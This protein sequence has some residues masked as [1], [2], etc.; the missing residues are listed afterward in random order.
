MTVEDVAA[1][2]AELSHDVDSPAGRRNSVVAFLDAHATWVVLA[3]AAFAV[4]VG[5]VLRY[6]YY[7]F[8]EPGPDSD[9]AEFGLLAEQLLRGELPL[10]MRGQP[11]GG[12]PWLFAIAASIRAFGMNSFGLRLPTIVLGLVNSGLVFGIG[13]Q[14]GWTRRRAVLAAAGVWC[15]PI[16]AVYFASR[17]TM[18]FVPAISG[19]LAALFFVLRME[20]R[21]DPDELLGTGVVS[22]RGLFLAG[23]VAGAGFWVNPGSFYLSGPT[24][25]W[26]GWRALR[27]AWA[28]PA[29]A[30]TRVFATLRPAVI[31]GIGGVVGAFP[32]IFLTV[33]GVDR[34]NN[35]AERDGYG[36]IERL[37]FFALQQ[38]PG[39][40]GFKTPIGGYLEGFWMGGVVW[41]V[42]FVAFCALLLLQIVRR[43]AMRNESVLS[44]LAVSVPII[45]LLV[46]AQSGPVYANLRYVFFAAPILGL[47]VASKW[48]TDLAAAVAVLVLPLISLA[49]VTSFQTQEGRTTEPTVEL[50]E[51]RGARCAIGD[52]WAGGHRLQFQSEGEIIAISTYENRNPLYIDQAED[53]GNCPWVFGDGSPTAA[54]FEAWLDDNGVRADVQ[55]P[56]D[57]QVVY[58]PERRVWLTEVFPDALSGD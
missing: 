1:P 44:V 52:Y 12:T 11:Y 7:S 27:E 25:A 36:L 29:S 55:R 35:Y 57:G 16:A 23:V 14:L 21:R 18:Y 30:P 9:E 20:A 13:V 53:L 54:Q 46:T 4:A 45:F 39:W 42:G 49:G 47:L 50:L 34:R 48:R 22:R 51:A 2:D 38:L 41:K 31:A 37:E 5:L 8:I 10:L 32:W 40:T 58:F 28:L 19:G 24:F 3:V 6:R 15:Y 26:I 43:G 17:E 56:G 33:L